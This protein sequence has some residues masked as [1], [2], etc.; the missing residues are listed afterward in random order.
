MDELRLGLGSDLGGSLPALAEHRVQP[1]HRQ[2][3]SRHVG[4]GRVRDH[5]RQGGPPGA[6]QIGVALDPEPARQLLRRSGPPLQ[7]VRPE[8]GE[9]VGMGHGRGQRVQLEQV[10]VEI[11]GRR[12]DVTEPPE[13]GNHP[14]GQSGRQHVTQH[15]EHRAGP[16]DRNPEVVQEL[17]VDVG[18]D[19]VDRGVHLGQVAEQRVGH[20]EVRGLVGSHAEPLGHRRPQRR[21]APDRSRTRIGRSP[22]AGC[23]WPAPCGPAR[24]PGRTPGA[25]RS[26]P[27][28]AARPRSAWSA[29]PWS[30]GP[31]RRSCRPRCGSRTWS[32]Q[33]ACSRT[34][35]AP[36]SR[37]RGRP[38]RSPRR[39]AARRRAS[40]RNPSPA[41]RSGGQGSGPPSGDG[42]AGARAR[43][44]PSA[45]ARRRCPDGSGT[46][47]GLTPPP[48]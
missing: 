30:S 14:I 27:G 9:I 22:P 1:L 21:Q 15:L 29:R 37:R 3:R 13:L 10:D 32:S 12:G 45:T 8:G 41:A 25:P 26:P 16:P 4:V 6:D 35:S 31:G 20:R 5:L 18:D 19:P 2:G 48:R 40:A 44:R 47:R 24:P 17:G 43:S 46:R 28:P 7:H 42:E 33:P 36:G 11:P 39:R 23:S 34:G 38:G